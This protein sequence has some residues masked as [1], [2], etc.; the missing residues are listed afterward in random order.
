[1]D[2][3]QLN[4]GDVVWSMV[5]STLLISITTLVIAAC[6]SWGLCQ[7]QRKPQTWNQG[8][9]TTTTP[10]REIDTTRGSDWSQIAAATVHT[11]PSLRLRRLS[12][13]LGDQ[14]PREEVRE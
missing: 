12:A 6:T 8:T 4:D 7:Q 3:R 5:M 1:M 11:M 10:D 14:T 13:L 9:Q 2:Y